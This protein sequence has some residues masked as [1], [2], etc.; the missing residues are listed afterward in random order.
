MKPAR[1]DRAGFLLVR[2]EMVVSRWLIPLNG[3]L[4]AARWFS[5]PGEKRGLGRKIRAGPDVDFRHSRQYQSAFLPRVLGRINR[6]ALARG[7]LSLSLIAWRGAK[8]LLGCGFFPRRKRL[9]KRL[10][11]LY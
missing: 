4:F 11:S 10:R 6:Q 5:L 3:D 9:R 7:V 2:C 1:S 8:M